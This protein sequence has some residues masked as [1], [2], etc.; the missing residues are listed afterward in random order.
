MP[1]L[2]HLE[3]LRMRILWSLLALL[4]GVCIGFWVVVKFDVLGLLIEPVRPYLADG[5]LTALGPTEPFMITLKLA[6]IVGVL[7]ASPVVIQQAWAS[8]SPALSPPGRRPSA[9]TSA[10]GPPRSFPAPAIASYV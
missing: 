2:D 6:L 7:L 8:V 3:V 10:P 9:P 5:K 1:F 4:V